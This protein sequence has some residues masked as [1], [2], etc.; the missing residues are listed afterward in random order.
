[1]PVLPVYENGKVIYGLCSECMSN[2]NTTELCTHKDSERDIE[3]TF[4]SGTF[5]F[6]YD[7]SYL[8]SV[9]S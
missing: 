1:M 7:M 2:G 3:G 9:F 5:L 4:V 6:T 8:H